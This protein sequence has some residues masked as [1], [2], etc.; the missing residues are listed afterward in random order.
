MHWRTWA[1]RHG[2]GFTNCFPAFIDERPARD[3]IAEHFIPGDVHLNRAGNEAIAAC[4][5]ES[6]S[7][8]LP[9]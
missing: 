9:R 2:A 8:E 4:V 6:L 3:V 5:T 7:S 1:E